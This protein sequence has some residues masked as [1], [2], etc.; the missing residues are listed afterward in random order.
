MASSTV[1]IC[2]KLDATIYPKRP[3][4]IDGNNVKIVVNYPTALGRSRGLFADVFEDMPGGGSGMFGDDDGF[5][6]FGAADRSDRAAAGGAGGRRTDQ[7]V[8]DSDGW[9][10]GRLS[11]RGGTVPN[12]DRCDA[13]AR[14][15]GRS[16][17]PA[18][19]HLG[20]R[21]DGVGAGAAAFRIA[22]AGG[23]FQSSERAAGRVCERRAED[24]SNDDSAA[25][26]GHRSNSVDTVQLL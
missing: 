18:D 19:R 25:E 22:Q 2:I 15:V 12:R 9:S 26:A 3:G 14:E 6:P 16:D 8:A 21:A 5:S 11:R 1:T 20:H 17:Q 24:F 10:A 23:R 13:D 4:K 7:C